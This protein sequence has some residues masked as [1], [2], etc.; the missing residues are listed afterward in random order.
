MP[1]RTSPRRT[2]SFTLLF[3]RQRT[4]ND[5]T[6][7]RDISDAADQSVKLD[8]RLAYHHDDVGVCVNERTS[9]QKKGEGRSLCIY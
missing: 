7:K 1:T 8:P 5:K 3:K 6:D 2:S 9:V 4:L